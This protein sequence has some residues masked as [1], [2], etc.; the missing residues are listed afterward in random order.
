MTN[1][2]IDLTLSD[3]FR[4]IVGVSASNLRPDEKDR[5]LCHVY[6]AAVINLF[7]ELVKRLPQASI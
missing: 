4:Q 6:A 7:G 1:A 2:D 5:A 3:T